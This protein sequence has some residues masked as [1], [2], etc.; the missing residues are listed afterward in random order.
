MGNLISCVGNAADEPFVFTD[1]HIELYT[2]EEICYYIYNYIDTMT[3]DAFDHSLTEWLRGQKGLEEVSGKME[4]LIDNHN[5]LKDKV[6]TL[7]C[8]CDYY[9]EKEIRDLIDV[10]DQLENMSLFERCRQKGN[11]FLKNG[12]Y[13]E[14]EGFLLGVLKS[15]TAKQFTTEECGD[16]LHN[17]A[18]IHVHTASYAEAAKEFRDAYERNHNKETLKQY[19]IALKLSEQ[20]LLYQKEL[21]QLQVEEILEQEVCAE[22]KEKMKE[23]ELLPEYSQLQRLSVMKQQGQVSNYYEAAEAMIEKW[24]QDYK[25]EAVG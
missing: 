19:L 10:M 14:A 22:L 24:K 25:E 16:I 9:K 11:Q 18:V 17:L 21:I 7:L 15:E 2:I 20:K 1:S 23:A 3:D 13:K 6:V 8:A 4:R 5:S 12:K